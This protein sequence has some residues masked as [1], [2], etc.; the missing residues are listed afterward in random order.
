MNALEKMLAE[1]E[2]QAKYRRFA[3]MV[4]DALIFRLSIPAGKQL[5]M[6]LG[7]GTA[8]DN[9]EAVRQWVEAEMPRIEEVEVTRVQAELALRLHSCLNQAQN[10][11]LLP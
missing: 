5:A 6:V 4:A 1:I 7:D 8:R 10:G 9:R 2:Q 3:E 11:D